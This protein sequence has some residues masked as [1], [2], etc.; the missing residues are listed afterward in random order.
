MNAAGNAAAAFDVEFVRAQFPILARRINGRPLVYLDNGASAQKPQCVLDAIDKYY[1]EFNAN[2]H[3]G[4][5]HL[6]QRA[7]RA[8]EDAREIARAAL[9]AAKSEEII[10]TGGATAGINLVASAWG[11]QNIKRGDEI[12]LTQMEHHSNI[13]PWQLLVETRGAKI[14]VLP[15]N[16]AGEL[17]LDELEKLLSA[18]TKL[19]AVAHVSNT[20]GTVNPVREVTERAHAHGARVLVDGAQAVPHSEVDV[21]ALDADFYAF[22]GH[23]VFGPTGVGVLY[24][25]EEL[26]AAMPPYQGGGEMIERVTFART[27]YAELP[28]KFEAG[29]PNIV[30]GIGLGVALNWFGQFDAD[31]LAAYEQDLLNYAEQELA[32]IPGLCIIGCARAKVGVLSFVVDGAHPFDIGAI[33]DQ[34]GIAVRTGHHC[35]Q[36]LMDFY[37][38][39]GTVRAS[40]ALYNTREEVDAL[41]AGVQRAVKMLVG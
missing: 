2:I 24:G 17:R 6:S 20:L 5:H 12:I 18:R 1:R 14:K 41:V 25:K 9:G 10:F 19:V 13:V 36:P 21:R 26:L 39:P 30:G 31:R 34:Q 8:Y 37:E 7:T 27:T 29:T 38:I 35:T 11:M 28:H 40:F 15:I 3:R 22:S 33:L 4:A 23:K 32:R 16:R